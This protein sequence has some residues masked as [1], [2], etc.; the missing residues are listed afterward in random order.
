M[1]ICVHCGKGVCVNC[2]GKAESGRQVCSPRCAATPAARWAR[3]NGFFLYSIAAA[4]LVAAVYYVPQN[5]WQLSVFLGIAAFAG[6]LVGRRT[7]LQEAY[8]E[9]LHALY[10]RTGDAM[11]KVHRF[12]QCIAQLLDFHARISDSPVTLAQLDE[13]NESGRAGLLCR[14]YEDAERKTGRNTTEPPLRTIAEN[15]AREFEFCRSLAE[16]Y[17][18]LHARKLNSFRGRMKLKSDIY[19]KHLDL[20]HSNLWL[21]TINNQLATQL[22]REANK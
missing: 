9:S 20:R 12:R 18:E 10:Y 17:F 15:D 3:L 5:L 19:G 16:D 11:E 21:T 1:A 6:V 4:F 14:V 22:N 8:G 13:A 2:A 7:L